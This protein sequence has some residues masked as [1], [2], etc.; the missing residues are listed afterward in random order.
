M[1]IKELNQALELLAKR[2]ENLSQT[3]EKRAGAYDDMLTTVEGE[4]WTNYDVA[5]KAFY[6]SEKEAK[7]IVG[8]RA[9]EAYD[10]KDKRV[11][12]G[13]SVVESTARNVIIPDRSAAE[14]WCREFAQALFVLDV[15]A[16]D[17]L[18]LGGKVP[19]EIAQ[20]EVV[21]TIRPRIDSDL[22]FLLQDLS[23]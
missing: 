3:K 15:E 4:K 17:D 7:V 10:G 16:F 18:V 23:V 12:P 13:A 9:V 14:A 19:E 8:A 5:Y 6:K 22:S 20:I 21:T 2:R 1:A 11:T